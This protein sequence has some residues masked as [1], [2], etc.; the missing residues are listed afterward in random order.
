MLLNIERVRNLCELFERQTVPLFFDFSI[1]FK[2]RGEAPTIVL[3]DD[4]REDALNENVVGDTHEHLS[5]DCEYLA[6]AHV[7][8]IFF[9]NRRRLRQVSH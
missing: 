6:L 4:M 7:R 5:I 2:N 1:N 9:R 3:Y 8:N